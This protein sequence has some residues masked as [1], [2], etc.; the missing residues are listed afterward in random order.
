MNRGFEDD[1]D[2]EVIC[3]PVHQKLEQVDVREASSGPILG[4]VTFFLQGAQNVQA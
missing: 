1:K 3:G 4:T 2:E